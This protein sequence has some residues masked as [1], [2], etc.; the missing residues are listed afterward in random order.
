M[1]EDVNRAR[2]LNSDIIVFPEAFVTGFNAPRDSIAEFT[3][4]LDSV[5]LAEARR[6]A[7]DNESGV[8]AV[9]GLGR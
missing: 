2:N 8:P 4:A 3:I 6:L 5:E 9:S 7:T 1:R